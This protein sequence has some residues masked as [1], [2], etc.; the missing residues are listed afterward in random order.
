[1]KQA[2][3]FNLLVAI[4]GIALVSFVGC[5][6][7]NDDGNGNGNGGGGGGTTTS[8]SD[9]TVPTVPNDLK[10]LFCVAYG[11]GTFVA[12]GQKGQIAYSTDNGKTWSINPEPVFTSSVKKIVYAEGKFIAISAEKIAY[13]SDPGGTWTIK[14]ILP[15]GYP[16]AYKNSYAFAYCGGYY[17]ISGRDGWIAY[18]TTLD[19]TWTTKQITAS[20]TRQTI[21]GI[22]YGN[23]SI[24]AVGIRGL[25]AHATTPDGTWT[26]V[27]DHPFDDKA[28]F[29]DVV[30]TGTTFVT[31][32]GDV[33]IGY[34]TN[35][36][37]WTKGKAVPPMDLASVAFG[38]NTLV[39]VGN[40]T[41]YT[42]DHTSTWKII[43]NSPFAST[44]YAEGVCF[45]NNTFVAVGYASEGKGSIA[46]TTVK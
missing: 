36:N 44:K 30:F 43:P 27:S 7:D 10:E 21:H 17:I 19:G 16:D 6:D 2:I 4:L 41:Y 24:V 26:V 40:A 9:W 33:T 18:S 28:Y 42:N 31:V 45:G 22:A 35:P 3:K 34:A 29:F 32:G 12:G 25:I 15:D 38:K 11:N 13:T 5:K 14:T 39:T 23:G 8:L 37:S 20:E 1:M 46:Y